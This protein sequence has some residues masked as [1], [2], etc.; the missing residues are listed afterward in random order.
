MRSM[1]TA[2]LCRYLCRLHKTHVTNQAVRFLKYTM[3]LSRQKTHNVSALHVNLNIDL[4]NVL[5]EMQHL[6]AE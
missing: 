6:G 4:L 3:G 1:N 5:Q 2:C